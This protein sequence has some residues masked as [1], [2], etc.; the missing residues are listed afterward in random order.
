[1]EKQE[2]KEQ[3]VDSEEIS[4]GDMGGFFFGFD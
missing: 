4:S 3:P 2:P 1:M